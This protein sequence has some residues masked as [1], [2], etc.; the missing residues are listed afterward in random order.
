MT[1]KILIPTLIIFNVLSC[2]D[3]AHFYKAA[4]FHGI[5]SNI[6]DDWLSRI[7]ASFGYG[8]ARQGYDLNNNKSPF[9]NKLLSILL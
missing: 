6:T 1:Y 9:L 3:N 7:N 2:I 5:E 4:H 8:S